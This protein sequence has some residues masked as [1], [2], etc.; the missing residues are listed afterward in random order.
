[1]CLEDDA[2]HK[3]EMWT[4]KDSKMNTDKYRVLMGLDVRNIDMMRCY[5]E[6]VVISAMFDNTTFF[7]TEKGGNVMMD[8]PEFV[9][10]Y[11]PQNDVCKSEGMDIG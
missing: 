2:P 5:G 3:N 9:E 11:T 7:T 8:T 6:N 1:M 10:F 4:F